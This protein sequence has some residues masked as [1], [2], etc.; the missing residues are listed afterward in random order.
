MIIL[1]YNRDES[2][3]SD[4]LHQLGD[5]L[6]DTY[7]IILHFGVGSICTD[8]FSSL[9]SF[10]EAQF[11]CKW[12]EKHPLGKIIFYEDMTIERLF[13]ESSSK[14]MN[15]LSSKVLGKI[16]A[17]EL[18]EYSKLLEIYEKYNGSLLKSSRA[19]YIHK[20]TLQYRL[21]KLFELTGYNPR[22][23]SDFVVLKVAFMATEI[24]SLL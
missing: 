18:T 11:G 22:N 23:L 20:N 16:N 1:A 24:K 5:Y 4:L 9:T 12:L 6:S 21:N 17:K 3:I 14:Q 13:I 2:T 8:E 10:K 7:L 15:T 19:L